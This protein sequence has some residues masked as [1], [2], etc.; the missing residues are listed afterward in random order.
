MFKKVKKTTFDKLG[1]EGNIINQQR[2]VNK[3][4]SEISPI[5]IRMATKHTHTQSVSKVCEEIGT[6]MHY[7]WECKNSTASM[8]NSMD[9]PQKIKNRT[10]I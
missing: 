1:I 7:W 6:L 8:E 2:D 4:H 5:P 9:I 10:T 3:K